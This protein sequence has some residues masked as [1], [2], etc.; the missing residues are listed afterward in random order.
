MYPK[1]S[2]LFHRQVISKQAGILKMQMG[3]VSLYTREKLAI[4]QIMLITIT[5]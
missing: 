5:H 3:Q 4:K 2:G 1:I